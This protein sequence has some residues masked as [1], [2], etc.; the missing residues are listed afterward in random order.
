[1]EERDPA[2]PRSEEELVADETDAAAAE[3]AEIGGR[4]SNEDEDPAQRPLDEAGQ[5]E[6]EGFEQAERALVEHASHGDEAPDP[7][8]LA[9][10]EAEHPEPEHGEADRAR[11]TARRDED[12]VD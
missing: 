10:E 6:A 2:E 3:A 8:S 1:M 4:G 11:S 9:S 12:V 5:G 7:D